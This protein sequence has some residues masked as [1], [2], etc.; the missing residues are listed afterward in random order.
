MEAL[1]RILKQVR[2]N[3]DTTSIVTSNYNCGK[4][5]DT[6]WLLNDDGKV[7]ARCECYQMD[8][9]RRIWESS[10]VNPSKVKLL[11]NYN[12]YNDSTNKAKKLAIEYIENFEEIEK[13]EKNWF[14][15]MGQPGAGK[16]HIVI[17]IG[18]ALLDKKIP[19]V[20]I[21]YIEATRELKSCATDTEYYNKLSDRYKKAKVLIID[22]LYK[23]KVRNGVL[24]G[25]LTEVDTKHIYPIL[26]YRYFNNLPTLFSTECTPDMLKKLDEAMGDR[27]IERLDRKFGVTF[28]QD[29]NYRMKAFEN[30]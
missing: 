29:S 27:I 18:K 6:T 28:K 5:K 10:G 12:S 11:K 26:N 3:Q 2:D 23:E 14:G 20:Y 17:A 19:V 1:E 4:C 21:S 9:T 13:L 15:L 24:V 8:Y 16:T 25:G 30:R 22:D 7:I